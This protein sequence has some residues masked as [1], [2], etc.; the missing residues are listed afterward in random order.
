MNCYILLKTKASKQEKYFL[1]FL[2][3]KEYY[4][5]AAAPL[6]KQFYGYKIHVHVS[7]SQ[8]TTGSKQILFKETNDDTNENAA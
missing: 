8:D 4:S 7:C 1:I 3:T 5:R 2:L 6:S